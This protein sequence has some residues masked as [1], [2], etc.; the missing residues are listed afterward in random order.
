MQ[1][2]YNNHKDPK[3]KVQTIKNDHKDPKK[4]CKPLIMTIK[5][6]KKMCIFGFAWF[7]LI[8]LGFGRLGLVK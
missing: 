6:Q 7:G 8:K 5:I 2:I 1:T 4:M 3:E